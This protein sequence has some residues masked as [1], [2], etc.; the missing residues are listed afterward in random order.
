M[1]NIGKTNS[2]KVVKIQGPNIYLGL[3]GSPMVLLADKKPSKA[4]QVGDSVPAF[5]Y[6]DGEGHLAA[7]LQKPLAEVGDIA[8]LKVAAVNYY[9]A[10]LD[11]GIP[12]DLLVPFSEQ[13]AEMK[14]GRS[15][16]VKLYED[17][18]GRI[19]ATT[20]LDRFLS[21][22]GPE[23]KAGQQVALL[24]A[25]PTELG[26]KA[27]V[28]NTHWGMLY[29]NELFRPLRKGQKLT[30]YIKKVRDDHKLDLTLN[31]PGYGKIDPLA[32]RI[33]AELDKHGGVLELGDKSP[34]EAIYAA[35]GTSKKAFK[36][37]IGALYKQQLI[38]IED[39]TVRRT[40]QPAG[41]DSV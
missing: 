28:D 21:D 4:C 19:A 24:I 15:Y 10:F 1:I 14:P 3:P 13:I 32:D 39:H 11:W 37:A 34:P 5:V 27:I 41:R 6:I 22:E 35:F 7:T 17:V 20:K 23:F 36:Q 12:K 16:L 26:V 38:V 33:L 40:G 8:W 29:Q 9:G 30:G 18:K 31:E 2:L 25:D